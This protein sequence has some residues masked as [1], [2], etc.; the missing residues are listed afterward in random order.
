[1]NR[2]K[3]ASEAWKKTEYWYNMEYYDYVIEDADTLYD[4]MRHDY[5]FLFAY[6][7]SLSKEAEYLKSNEVLSEG[8]EISSDPM[9]WIVMGNNNL[10]LERYEEAEQ[11]YKHA[12]YMVPNRLY[13]LCRLAE[14][15]IKM[16]DY[17]RFYDMKQ[18]IDRFK[19]KV[20]S[21]TTDMLR[22]RMIELSDSITSI[23]EQR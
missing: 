8:T 16:G 21:P 15:Y 23:N 2:L 5:R 22:K 9:F 4:Y 18:K 14:L 12:F 11:C 6:G 1:M 20:E 17:D 7:Q 10:S 13:P 3:E 19:S